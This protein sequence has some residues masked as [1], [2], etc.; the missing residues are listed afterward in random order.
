[1]GIPFEKFAPSF[2]NK[3]PFVI[4]HRGFSKI[5]PEN[6]IAS[7][8][9]AIEFGANMIEFDI[10]L[11]SNDEFVVIHDN[12]L[13]R[14]VGTNEDVYELS[15]NL[16]TQLD[17]G[18]WFDKSFSNEKIP[19]LN[20]LLKIASPKIFLNIEIKPDVKF[21][22][23]SMAELLLKSLD[24]FS[25]NNF[26]C[27]SSFNHKII[28]QIKK[29]NPTITTGVLYNSLKDFRNSPSRLAK[30]VNAE[31]FICNKHQINFDV[32]QN[33]HQNKIA[34]YVYGIT[35]KKDVERLLKLNIDGLIADDVQLVKDVINEHL[36]LKS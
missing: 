2:F 35:S 15:S 27:V 8:K 14:T 23:N 34:V 32:V 18:S 13:K 5:A 28:T 19:H 20:N 9:K 33:A 11:T 10:Q 12:N 29:L 31:I 26:I 25:K 16:L 17:C 4:G 21:K 6:T 30:K 3:P 1:M 24:G 36:H 22:N 7:F